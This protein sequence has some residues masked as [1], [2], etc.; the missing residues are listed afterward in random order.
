MNKKYKNQAKPGA[1]I[2]FNN[3]T[4]VC[5]VPWFVIKSVKISICNYKLMNCS[6]FTHLRI[7]LQAKLLW[8]TYN[9]YI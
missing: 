7:T 3:V 5:T 1:P 8:Y 6:T 2:T 4:N 9:L